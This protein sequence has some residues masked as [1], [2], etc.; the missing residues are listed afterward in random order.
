MAIKKIEV[1][2]EDKYKLYALKNAYDKMRAYVDLCDYE[3]G[4]HGLIKKLDNNKGYMLTDVY[5]LKQEVNSGT[6]EIDEDAELEYFNGMTKE[7]QDE[8]M[9]INRLWGHSHNTMAA[10]ASGQDDS[11]G[12]EH[13]KDV[14]DFYIRLITNKKNEYYITIYDKEHNIEVTIDEVIV[15]DPI[16]I[17]IRAQVK[18]EIEDKVKEKKYTSSYSGGGYNYQKDKDKT[19]NVGKGVASATKNKVNPTISKFNIKDIFDHK[20]YKI[21]LLFG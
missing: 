1:S 8:F 7:Q 11:Q 9:V 6:C 18:K 14:D 2:N 16:N 4:W 13:A 3:I 10:F 5:L 20:D 17:D 12:R 19:T 21:K 15:Y